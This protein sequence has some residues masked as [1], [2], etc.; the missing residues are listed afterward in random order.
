MAVATKPGHR[1][2]KALLGAVT[3]RAPDGAAAEDPTGGLPADRGGEAGRRRR[4]TAALVAPVAL[5]AS[6]F[7]V[8]NWSVATFGLRWGYLTGF[9]F[10]WLV[11]CLGFSWWA[12]G[13]RGL[14][15]VFRDVHPR[16][17]S[18]ASLWVLLLA[19]PVVGGFLTVWLPSA[20][21]AT[22]GVVVVALAIAAVNATLEELL[23]RGVY[24]RLFAD[25]LLLGWLYAPS[26]CGTSRPPASW[27]RRPSS[28]AGRC[29]WGSS[30]DTSPS[31][32]SRCDGRRWRTSSSTPWAWASHCSCSDAPD[33]LTPTADSRP[34][35]AARG[36]APGRC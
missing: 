32:R 4:R 19:V 36:A 15:D 35:P 26:P 1:L 25:R 7:V 9:A 30:T 27:A 6:T 20:A 18:P 17:P 23:W 31:T 21:A 10:F 2:R 24:I 28:W 12:L 33:Q 14:V 5:T 16:L 8:F 34:V 3:A 13:T 29:T 22:I 11:W